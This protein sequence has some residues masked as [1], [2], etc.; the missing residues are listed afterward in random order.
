[1]RTGPERTILVCA[2]AAVFVGSALLVGHRLGFRPVCVWKAATGIPC[3]GCG[4]TRALS[5]LVGGSAG[6]ALRWN[7]GAVLAA[8]ALAAACCYAFFVLAFRFEPWRP[9]FLRS[10]ILRAAVLLGLVA[11]WIFVILAARA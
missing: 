2:A 1:M 9:S 11:N 4:G 7:P 8:A 3:A 5:L 6:E 10:R